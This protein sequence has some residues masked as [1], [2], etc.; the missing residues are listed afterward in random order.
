MIY[1]IDFETR[2]KVKIKHGV[3]RYTDSAEALFLGWDVGL[4]DFRKPKDPTRLLNHVAQ[5]GKVSAWNA[6]F[7]YYVWNKIMVPRYGWPKLRLDQLIDTMAMAAAANLPQGLAACGKIMGMDFDQLKS[8]RGNYLIKH[9]TVPRK[10]TKANPDIFFQEPELLDEFGRYCQ[11]DIIAEKVIF[12][13]LPMLSRYEQEA[14]ELTQRINLRGVPIDIPFVESVNRLRQEHHVE[15]ESRSQELLGFSAMQTARITEHLGLDN[16]QAATVEAALEHATGPRKEALELRKAMAGTGASKFT[17]IPEIICTDDTVKNLFVYHGAGT[18][19]W[20]S[21]GGLNVQNFTRPVINQGVALR[22]MQTEDLD[23]INMLGA[24][25]DFFNSVT[26]SAIHGD[27]TDADYSSVEN[28]VASWVANDKDTLE[29]FREGLDQYKD[30]ASKMYHVPRET[31]SGEQRQIAKSAVLGGQFGQGAKGFVDFAA[32]YGVYIDEDE[33][34]EIIDAYRKQNPRIVKM[35]YS[36]GDKSIQAVRN[37]GRIIK[38]NDKLDFLFKG[39]FLLL[40]LPSGRKLHWYKPMVEDKETPWGEVRPVVTVIGMD[41]Y[42]RQ[43]HRVK[44]IGANFF[45]SAVQGIARDILLNGMFNLE[46]RGVKIRMHVHDEVLADRHPGVSVEKFCDL[47]CLKPK[48]A[49]GLPLAAEGW[50]G[51]RYKK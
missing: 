32:G 8:Q 44:S 26:R 34:K 5:G 23:F 45:Q 11:Q 21:R 41:S 42:S 49:K 18:G 20:A 28:R 13:K 33:S 40:R 37:K 7:E 38:V 2:S 12:N 19:R 1:S 30:M 39:D 16:I 3:W 10:P 35:W 25:S 24:P 47:M 15:L 46:D 4:W 14:W 17:K 36:M 31:V 29:L 9:L 22:A 51:D 48:W 27:F 50:N 43:H 6:M